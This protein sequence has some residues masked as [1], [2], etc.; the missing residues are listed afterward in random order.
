MSL[1][2]M[3]NI[4]DFNAHVFCYYILYIDIDINRYRFP[5]YFF[6][7]FF[8]QPKSTSNNHKKSPKNPFV[9]VQTQKSP[10]N[11]THQK[12]PKNQTTKIKIVKP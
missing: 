8:I 5:Y 1:V 2:M 11:Q 7:S 4:L 3:S 10:I 9:V 6:Y 12:L